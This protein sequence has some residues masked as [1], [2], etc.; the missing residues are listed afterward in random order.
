MA[1]R[2]KVIPTV[3][4]VL[5]ICVIHRY[6]DCDEG[7]IEPGAFGLARGVAFTRQ[8]SVQA[9]FVIVSFMTQA[10]TQDTT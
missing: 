5:R 9:L 10:K 1:W 2:Q 3:F 8:P 6:A 7:F 4:L